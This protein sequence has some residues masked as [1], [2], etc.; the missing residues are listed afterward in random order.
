MLRADRFRLLLV[1][2]EVTLRRSLATFLR[3][4]DYEVWTAADAEE[5]IDFLERREFDLVL[6]DISMPG[7]TGI[8]LLE[9]VKVLDERIDVIMMTGYLDIS[10]AIQAMRRGA[11]DFFAKPFNFEKIRLT[12]ERVRERHALRAD[13]DRYRLLKREAALQK[14]T[15]LSLARAAEERDR[16]NIGHGRRVAAYALRLGKRLCYSKS[17][18]EA[19]DYAAKLH[20]IGKIGVD[21]AILNKPGKLDDGEFQSMKR[22]SEIGEYILKPVSFFKEI[23]PVIRSHHEHY[24]GAGYPDGLIGEDIP[25][26]SRI[27]FLCDYFDAITSERPYRHPCGLNEALEMLGKNRDKL[28]DPMLVDVFTELQLESAATT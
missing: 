6:T 11:Y 24:N 20:D 21:D 7:M 19:L 14:E 13:A 27:I 3:E 12:V 18:L 17:K 5:A 8:E 2:D 1:E 9:H 22:H 10:H 28:F 16:M 26:D 15:T 23:A 4:S 25:L